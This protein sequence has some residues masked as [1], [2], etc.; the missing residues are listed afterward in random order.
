MAAR[1]GLGT[2]KLQILYESMKTA[3]D[4]VEAGYVVDME[5]AEGEGDTIHLRLMHRDVIHYWSSPAAKSGPLPPKDL[6]EADLE[7]YGDYW[8]IH[9]VAQHG[10]GPLMYEIAMEY[11][12][13]NGKGLIP[14]TAVAAIHGYPMK[15]SDASTKVWAKFYERSD[16]K[17]ERLPDLDPPPSQIPLVC[18]YTKPPE[19]INQ[20]RRGNA[21]LAPERK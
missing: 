10:W 21:I 6:G 17:H 15:D 11:A 8:T 7:K 14:A 13:A 19:V 9:I 18:V 1:E 12:T 5:E 16:V 2:M 3:A 20:L 4:L